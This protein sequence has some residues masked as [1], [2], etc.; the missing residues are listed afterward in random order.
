[1]FRDCATLR[2]SRQKWTRIRLQKIR[3]SRGEFFEQIRQVLCGKISAGNDNHAGLCRPNGL[4]F[5]GAVS[6]S[7]VSADRRPS[8]RRQRGE[9]F[10]I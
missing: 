10:R 3:E 6:E 8:L 9:P 4:N 7:F 5:V 1:M 2:K